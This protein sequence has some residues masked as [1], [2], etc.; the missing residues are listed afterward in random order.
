[1]KHAVPL[2]VVAG[3]TPGS[4]MLY[5]GREAVEVKRAN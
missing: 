4:Y 2:Q 1:M 5:A 3:A